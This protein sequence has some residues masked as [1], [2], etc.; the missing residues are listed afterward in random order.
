LV[1]VLLLEQQTAAQEGTSPMCLIRALDERIQQ[2]F[3]D[4]AK[5]FGLRRIIYPGAYHET[6]WRFSP[7][8]RAELTA[9]QGLERAGLNLVLYLAGRR[10]LAEPPAKGLAS[11]WARVGSIAGPVLITH[12]DAGPPPGTPTATDLWERSRLALDAFSRQ[13]VVTFAE[14]DWNFVARP[15]RATGPRCLE[16]HRSDPPYLATSGTPS[17]P[18]QIGDALGVVL[19]GYP[20]D[21]SSR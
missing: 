11:P 8:D 19:Y 17:R 3:E 13:D 1:G 10:V 21:D 6:T 5:G 14:R 16:C 7:E 12:P 18:V 15:V 4:Q 9:V 20:R 2:R